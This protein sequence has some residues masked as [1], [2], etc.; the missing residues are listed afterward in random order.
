[1]IIYYSTLSNPNYKSN[2]KDVNNDI[3]FYLPPKFTY[4]P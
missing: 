1:M 4:N 2:I 3:L